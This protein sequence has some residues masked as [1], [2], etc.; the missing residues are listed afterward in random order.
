MKKVKFLFLA[1]L[2]LYLSVSCGVKNDP[3]ISVTGL[4]NASFSQK[5]LEAMPMIESNYT[6]KDDE[7][8][9]YMGIALDELLAGQ[10][11]EVY[12]QLNIIALDGYS[13]VVTFDEL[14]NCSECVLS[15]S[16]DNGW[17][18]V[19]PEFSGKLQVKDVVELNVE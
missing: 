19:M 12:S 18:S 10:G 9:V 2:V 17:S 3:V 16:D 4:K 11:I 1:L 5:D 13:A 7:T 14:S 6:N 15:Y 8:T